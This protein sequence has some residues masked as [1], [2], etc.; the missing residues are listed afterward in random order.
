MWSKGFY[1]EAPAPKK[2]TTSEASLSMLEK[3]NIHYMHMFGDIKSICDIPFRDKLER[4]D[5]NEEAANTKYPEKLWKL[6]L[7]NCQR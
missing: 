1:L 4:M 3:A 7:L 2:K 6:I 5:D